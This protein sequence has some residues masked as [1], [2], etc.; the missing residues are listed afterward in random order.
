MATSEMDGC[1]ALP[2]SL[3][4]SLLVLVAGYV[5][6]LGAILWSLIAARKWA[7]AELA[8]PESIRQWE[9]WREDVWQ[10]DQRPG[11][12]RRRV[13]KSAEPPA[14]V[15]MRDYF[16]VSLVGA[17]LFMTLLYWVVAWFVYGIL[18]SS[19]RSASAQNAPRNVG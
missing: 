16:A 4:P 13:P 1:R 6:L 15:L 7:L 3:S 17:V 12:V 9:A 8:T 2:V 14:L 18:H 11:P 10:Q 5:L 19:A